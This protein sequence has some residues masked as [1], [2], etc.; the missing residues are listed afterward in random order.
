MNRLTKLP[1]LLLALFTSA[2]GERGAENSDSAAADT[3]ATRVTDSLPTRVAS[4]C[5][6]RRM[7]GDGI[8]LLRI[9]MP[10]DSVPLLC[11]VTRDTIV[12]GTEGM[13][14][15][16]VSVAMDADTVLAEI[17]DARVWRILVRSQGIY[18]SD[19]LSVGSSIASLTPLPGL[20]P[21]VGEGYLYVATPA[22]CGMSFRLSEPP[23][24]AP[25]GEW[26]TAD[27][28]NL[29]NTVHVTRILLIGCNRQS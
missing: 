29:V 6:E 11:R 9:G 25:H 14:S 5:N 17:V 13:M 4:S 7:T 10:V 23:S 22:H 18:T 2:C 24:S 27:L 16:V 3:A 20:N 8:G 1:L 28:L 12:R 19:S 15:R 21:M 26:T